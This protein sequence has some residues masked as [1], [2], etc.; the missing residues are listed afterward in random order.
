MKVTISQLTPTDL[1]AVDELMKR[2]GRTLGFLPRGA[3]QSYLEKGSVLG[4]KTETGQ[5]RWLSSLCS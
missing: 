2:Y 3:L 1:G 5:L 4:T